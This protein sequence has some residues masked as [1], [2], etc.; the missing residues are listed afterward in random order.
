MTDDLRER[1]DRAV[2]AATVPDE[3]EPRRRAARRPTLATALKQAKKLGVSV[4]GATLT[5]D[6]VTLTFGEPGATD[7]APNPWTRKYAPH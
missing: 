5:A 7:D 4:S 6:G 3:P 1:I 2:A